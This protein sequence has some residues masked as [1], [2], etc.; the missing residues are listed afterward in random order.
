M[1]P[2]RVGRAH[3][4]RMVQADT[5]RSGA[6][7]V[8]K[9]IFSCVAGF[10]A[11]AGGFP[12]SA[13]GV[14]E[15]VSYVGFL[16]NPTGFGITDSVSVQVA[17]FVVETDG[18]AVWDEDLGPVDVVDGQ[19]EIILGQND[20]TA[21]DTALG[22]S[23]EY[24]LEFTI[25]GELLS[26]RQ[27]IHSIP[28]ARHA[29]NAQML[30][31]MSPDDFVQW[32]AG[33]VIDVSGIKASGQTVV[34]SSGTW[35]GSLKVPNVS[36]NCTPE[37]AGTI[38][39]GSGKFEGCNG[40]QWVRLDNAVLAGASQSSA[41]K[42]CN[43][44]LLGGGSSGSGLYWLDPD[45]DGNTANAFQAYCDM[46]TSGGGWTACAAF[47]HIKKGDGLDYTYTPWTTGSKAFLNAIGSVAHYG[48]FCGSL[49]V[50]QMFAQARTNTSSV[51]F[52]TA[53]VT[54][55][56]VNPFAATGAFA[57]SSAGGYIKFFNRSA[58]VPNGQFF[59]GGACNLTTNGNAQG[60]DL[61]VG[62]G[63]SYQQMMGNINNS[64]VGDH[65]C[66]M[67]E[68]CGVSSTNIVVFFVK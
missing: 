42:S 34:D 56:G 24:W 11:M 39:F 61:C 65:M 17:L 59:V 51:A 25:N 49:I 48:N 32:D 60:T 3:G 7:N 23:N 52:T 33:G 10:L 27:R 29:G 37:L 58:M 43:D 19:F 64:N 15:T 8:T 12:P 30:S 21:L 47:G 14:P 40:V 45:G 22:A 2:H 13:W 67:N 50:S 46:S 57:F 20:P 62:D 1:V 9:Q 66:Q 55:S 53:P 4:H 36:G 41:A 63:T 28:F 26:P 16:G 44:V 35:V 18:I 68:A 38:R 5:A 6:N 31:G 54:T